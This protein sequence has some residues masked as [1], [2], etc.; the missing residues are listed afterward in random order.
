MPPAFRLLSCPS[1]RFSL[2]SLRLDAAPLEKLTIERINSE[3]ALAGTLPTRLAW[4]PDG[5]R[6][7]F[8]RRS[9]ESSSLY[10]LDVTKGSEAQLLDGSTLKAPGDKPLPL[11]SAS[12]LPDGRTLLV[13]AHGDIF[14][15]DVRTSQVRTLVQSPETE[16]YAEAS[17]DGRFV[18]FVRKSDLYVVEVETASVVRLTQNG[19][20]TLLNGKLDWVYEEEL[21]SRSGQGFVW[22]PDSRQIAYLQ[23][24]QSRVPTFPIVDFLPVRNEVEWERYPKAGAP[25]ADRAPRCRG[26]RQGRHPRPGAAAVVRPRRRLR[27]AA[28]RLERRL[29]RRRL[30]A[31]EPRPGPPRAAPAAR[32]GVAARGARHAP[33]DPAPRPRRPGSTPSA[34]RAS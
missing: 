3:P 11:A 31:P 12:W 10:A 32:A 13:P 20:D 7:T 9:G 21:A 17:P 18:A 19:S 1:C 14:T 8:L 4:H 34:L 15:V 26:P 6:L 2:S 25:N 23:L 27:P 33:H 29:A 22:S 5:K 24:D 28:A 30:P 16:E